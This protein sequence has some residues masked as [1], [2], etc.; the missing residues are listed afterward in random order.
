MIDELGIGGVFRCLV[1]DGVGSF[2]YFIVLSPWAHTDKG[3]HN[4]RAWS[5]PRLEQH[6]SPFR[7]GLVPE[8]KQ[9]KVGIAIFKVI[10]SIPDDP[11]SHPERHGPTRADKP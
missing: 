2:G 7:D 5:S 3:L 10:R 11:P 9:R 6:P 4:G 8:S 1:S